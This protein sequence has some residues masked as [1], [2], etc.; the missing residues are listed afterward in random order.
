[1]AH[2]NQ[3]QRISGSGMNTETELSAIPTVDKQLIPIGN[4]TLS[5]N[6]RRVRRLLT[7]VICDARTG[8]KH[9]LVSLAK[10][11]R[12]IQ[13]MGFELVELLEKKQNHE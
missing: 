6:V 4:K 12:A 10:D 7:A 5:R 1:M 8:G 9:E 2:P 3:Q 11:V 13:R